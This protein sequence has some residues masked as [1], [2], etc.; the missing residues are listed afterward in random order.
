MPR[1]Q[2]IKR[3]L[4]VTMVAIVCIVTSAAVVEQM[5]RRG[6]IRKYPAPGKLVAIE[7]GR[8]IQMDCRGS[9][10]PTVVLESGLD[11][12]G[13]LSWGS[14]QDSIATTT[15]VCSYSRAGVLW[16]DATPRFSAKGVA[17]DLHAALVAGGETAP[18][19]MVGHSIGG[20]YVMTFTR[21]F[22][23]EV[24][25]V[26]FVD[27]SHPD[28]FAHFR[29]ATGKY[30][31]PSSTTASVGAALS[32]TGVLRL[33]PPLPVASAITSA[34]F[35]MSLR[36]VVREMEAVPATL[37]C[38]GE[39][40]TLGSKPLVVLSATRQPP[41]DELKMMG[42]DSLQSMRLAEVKR[43]LQKDLATW[44]SNSRQEFVEGAGHYIQLDR[45]DAVIAAVR[46]VI[47]SVRQ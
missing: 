6:V 37:A 22:D 29:V 30:L 33:L 17:Q 40:R 28:Q 46:G 5:V 14:V 8:R 45:P 21:L 12:F 41:P 23:A 15:R 2:W 31:A 44:S 11:L 42:L 3:A 38:G 13:S 32:W 34:F 1:S 43:M 35:P 19:V 10:S 16:S 7:G 25:G 26:V 9:G 27:V 20:P 4:L 36:A 47:G 24:S 39:M 18:Y